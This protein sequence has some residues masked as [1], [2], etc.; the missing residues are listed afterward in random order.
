MNDVAKRIY[1]KIVLAILAGMLC[2][3]LISIIYI[4]FSVTPSF[5]ITDMYTDVMV[6]I[7]MWEQKSL[8]PQ[9]WVFGNQL[10]VMATPVLAAL[11]Y[12]ITRDAFIAM[13]AASSVM[14][15]LVVVSFDW[16][17][18]PVIRSV[19][20][21]LFG[22]VTFLALVVLFGDAVKVMNGWQL[23]FTMCAYYACYAINA[24][25]VFGYYIRSESGFRPAAVI[26]CCVLSFAMGIQSLR[27]TAVMVIPLLAVECFNILSR[28]RQHKPIVTKSF[29][30]T[31]VIFG[32]NIAGLV[33][34]RFLEINQSDMLGV[35]SFTSLEQIPE[36]VFDSVVTACSLFSRDTLYPNTS[37]RILLLIYVVIAIFLYVRS[38]KN[39][40]G[41]I[42]TLM[43]LFVMSVLSIFGIDVVTTMN[44]RGI[45]YFMIFPLLAFLSA[46]IY[47]LKSEMLKNSLLAVL[48]LVFYVSCTQEVLPAC[49]TAYDRENDQSYEISEYLLERDYTTIYSSWNRCENVAVASGGEIKA[50][51]WTEDYDPFIPVKFLCKPE[52]YTVEAER[53]VYMFYGKEN[54]EIGVEKA[55]AQHIEMTLV[56]QFPDNDIYLYAAPVNL[57]Q[58][59]SKK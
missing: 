12:G 2:I 25:L 17:L 11:F 23:L 55:K 38:M 43:V 57:L 22:I 24:F 29:V 26:L 6:A 42:N 50:G 46:Y 14:A 53:A 32:C 1:R 9:D 16:M 54:A 52:I 59:F 45:Y 31:A 33:F 8:F 36:A 35:L 40:D 51:F 15:I 41:Q 4:N 28:I 44:V 5:Y 7:E 37:Y 58:V 30:F 10:Y 3:Y 20:A 48:C 13:A 21:R 49:A 19:E 27:Q 39:T 47:T 34:K 18:R 56:A